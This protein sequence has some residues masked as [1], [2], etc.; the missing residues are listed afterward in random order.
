MH[1]EEGAG[2]VVIDRGLEDPLGV[3]AIIVL[4][5]LEPHV[6]LRLEHR[7]HHPQPLRPCQRSDPCPQLDVPCRTAG[8]GTVGLDAVDHPEPCRIVLQRGDLVED[9]PLVGAVD[10]GRDRR[11]HV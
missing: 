6:A 2:R 10:A 3:V 9:L 4:D 8:I 7:A 1:R 11:A 5:T